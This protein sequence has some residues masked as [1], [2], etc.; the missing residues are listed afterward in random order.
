M[1]MLCCYYYVV[2]VLLLTA[3]CSFTISEPSSTTTHDATRTSPV[4]APKFVEE[5]LSGSDPLHH[6]LHVG[7]D[8]MKEQSFRSDVAIKEESPPT[9]DVKNEQVSIAPTF[10]EQLLRQYFCTKKL[11]IQNVTIEKLFEALLYEKF[12]H[13]MLMKLTPGVNLTNIL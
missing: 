3:N 2:V 10:N 1:E 6:Q 11:Q 5:C 8:P 13:K 7:T 12:W 9:G 4:I